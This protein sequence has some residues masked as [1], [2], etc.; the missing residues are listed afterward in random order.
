[1][2]KISNGY[3]PNRKVLITGSIEAKGR[4]VKQSTEEFFKSNIPFDQAQD[5]NREIAFAKADFLD[6]VKDY[7]KIHKVE[8]GKGQA[9]KRFL[10]AFNRGLMGKDIKKRLR[11]RHESISKETYYN[12]RRKFRK[13]GLSGLL[14]GYNNGGN[15]INPII[16]EKI[17][18]LI[19]EN[20][21]CRYQDICDD[22]RVMFPKADLPHYSTIKNYAKEY[23]EKKYFGPKQKGGLT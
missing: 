10:K 14:E 21:L 23:K 11:D 4:S 5:W 12:W 15:R 8:I 13:H 9:L 6:L 16:K 19:W 18:R 7:I 20:H 1:M 2:L 17:E 3:L 22:L